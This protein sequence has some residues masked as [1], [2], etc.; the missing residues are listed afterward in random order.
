VR[1]T[2]QQ[3]STTIEKTTNVSE[4]QKERKDRKKGGGGRNSTREQLREKRTATVPLART[5][6]EFILKMRQLSLHVPE[7]QDVALVHKAP[8]AATSRRGRIST[9]NSRRIPNKK[10]RQ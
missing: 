10:T 6:C 5:L 1:R 4:N 3:K 8:T 7:W 2:Q 9:R